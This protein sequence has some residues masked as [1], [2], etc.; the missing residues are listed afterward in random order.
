[1]LR[2]WKK[3]LIL[4]LYM[5]VIKI[6]SEHKNKLISKPVKSGHK[7]VMAIVNNNGLIQ[8]RHIDILK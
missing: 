5:E 4:K 3:Q 2:A 8:T 1:M 7:R 6:I